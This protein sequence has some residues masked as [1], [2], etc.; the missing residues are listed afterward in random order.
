MKVFDQR[1]AKILE[2]L[3][4]DEPDHSPKGE[5]DEKV[6]K[7]L[8]LINNQ[9]DY[10]TTSSCSGRAVVFLSAVKEKH[11]HN[12]DEQKGRWLMITHSPLDTK[13]MPESTLDGMYRILFD[14]LVVGKEWDPSIVAPRLVTLKFEPLVSRPGVSI[15]R[16]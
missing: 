3:R 4:S 11:K 6:L 5:V 16:L 7:L 2:D 15:H 12:D 13:W 9:D 1:K 10:V 14:D 8:E